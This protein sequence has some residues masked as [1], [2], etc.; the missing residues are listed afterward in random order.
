MS[1][2]TRMCIASIASASVTCKMD[3]H[4]FMLCI[5]RSLP[6]LWSQQLWHWNWNELEN[7]KSWPPWDTSASP[8]WLFLPLSLSAALQDWRARG[9]SRNACWALELLP[10]RSASDVWIGVKHNWSKL[11]MS[12]AEWILDASTNLWKNLQKSVLIAPATSA[13][14]STCLNA[15]QTV[16][17]FFCNRIGS[18][19]YK[20]ENVHL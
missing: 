20:F 1:A 16:G 3:Q 13:L 5:K 11:W 6:K 9:R 14:A 19:F 4:G 2:N 12:A 8:L 15:D 10:V 18:S 7:L 17:S